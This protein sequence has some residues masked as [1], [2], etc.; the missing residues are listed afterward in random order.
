MILIPPEQLPPD[1]L[2]AIIETFVLREGTDYG[3]RD[4]SLS[5]K[6]QQVRLQIQRGQI[7][8]S[9]D[10]NTETCNLMTKESYL[11]GGVAE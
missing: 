11:R 10:E 1:T 3:D 5:A 4:V 2:T 6:V 8:I 9:F 7:L